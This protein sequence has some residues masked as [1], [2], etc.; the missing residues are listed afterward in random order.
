MTSA[1]G[2]C[3][4]VGGGASTFPQADVILDLGKKVSVDI[5]GE[6]LSTGTLVAVPPDL[7]LKPHYPDSPCMTSVCS[8]AQ[9][10]R[11]TFGPSNSTPGYIPKR[12]ETM[13]TQTCTQM[14]ITVKK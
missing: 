11:I 4:E 2:R 9:H 12:T 7:S 10:H 5:V 6:G 3:R 14:L 13:P 1:W 8:E